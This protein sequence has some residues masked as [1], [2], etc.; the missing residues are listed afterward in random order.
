VFDDNGAVLVVVSTQ[1]LSR[2]ASGLRRADVEQ[3]QLGDVNVIDLQ[4]WDGLP[5]HLCG[6]NIQLEYVFYKTRIVQFLTP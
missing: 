5:A 6:K 2:T 4:A 1:S 3:R